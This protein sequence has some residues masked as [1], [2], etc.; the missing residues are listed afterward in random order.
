MM[1]PRIPNK[2]DEMIN[3][4]SGG[5]APWS[6]MSPYTNYY[7]TVYTFEWHL[8]TI[9][10]SLYLRYVPG[11]QS[12]VYRSLLEAIIVTNCCFYKNEFLSSVQLS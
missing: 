8:D 6:A 5:R 2:I 9:A 3:T 10:I 1:T 4:S 12:I 11:Y 7:N